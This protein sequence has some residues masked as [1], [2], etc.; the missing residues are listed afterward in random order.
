M[1]S[2]ARACAVLGIA[3]AVAT[4]T[5]GVA[6]AAPSGFDVPVYHS[7]GTLVGRVQGNLTWS[8]SGRTV[9]FTS[10]QLYVRDG[11]CVY[12]V[13]AGYQGN[14]LLVASDK[15]KACGPG[16]GGSPNVSLSTDVPGGIQHV[17]IELTD[18][19]HGNK[20]S[21]DCFKTE[22]VCRSRP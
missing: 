8:T 12:L 4:G 7:S 1:R 3:A 14:T 6:A 5:A 10:Q 17:I 18:V 16:S 19:A 11:E 9:S 15:L 2:A 20:A 21:D 22:S 13:Y